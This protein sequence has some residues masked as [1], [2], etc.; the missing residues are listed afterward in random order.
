MIDVPAQDLPALQALQSDYQALLEFVHL[1]PVGLVRARASG[2][3]LMMNP[4][5]AQLLAPLGF[6]DA[7]AADGDDALNLLAILDRASPDIR[8]LVQGFSGPGV[9]C[10]GYRVQLPEVAAPAHA[11]AAEAPIALGV[12]VLRLP[13]DPDSLMV[14]LTDESAALKLHRLQASWIR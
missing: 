12:T 7:D 2:E 9:V 1:A 5:A 8:M 11:A 10:E 3:V 4:Q 13:S 14:V 6:G